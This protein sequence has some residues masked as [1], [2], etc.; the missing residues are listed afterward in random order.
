MPAQLLEALLAHELGHVRRHDYLVNLLQN[1]IETLLFYHPAVWW[2][3]R[4]IC[5]ERELIAD[6]I[7]ARLLGEPRRLALALSELE[8][9]QFS[10]HHL[11]QAANGGD[12]MTRIKRLLRPDTQALN[13]RAAIPVLGLAAICSACA[14]APVAP[15]AAPADAMAGAAKPVITRTALIDFNSCER[16]QYPQAELAAAHEGTVTMTFLT[17]PDGSVGESKVTKSSGFPAL[18]EAALTALSKCRFRPAMADGK[19]FQAW[20][21]VKYVWTTK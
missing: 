18:D 21:P 13:W 5:S 6:D 9:L 16:P 14:Q 17:Q 2:I 15:P 4:R 1:V 7:A 3:S 12:L 10:T 19:L 20:V 11:A 8:R